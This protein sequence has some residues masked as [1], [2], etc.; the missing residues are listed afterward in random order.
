MISVYHMCL[1]LFLPVQ[2]CLL[3]CFRSYLSHLICGVCLSLS[4]LITLPQTVRLFLGF[5]VFSGSP[6][7]PHCAFLFF[8][9]KAWP[10]SQTA[11]APWYYTLGIPFWT[12]CKDS[13]K[14]LKFDGKTT[15]LCASTHVITHLHVTERYTDML[16]MKKMA[17]LVT[18]SL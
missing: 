14:R 2:L 13:H 12:S 5:I 11:R 3:M 8:D 6:T 16:H 7:A 10:Q 17:D 9:A 1:A 18:V 15:V 4:S